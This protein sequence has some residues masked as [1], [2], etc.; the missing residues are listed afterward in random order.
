MDLWI[1]R[2]DHFPFQT[3]VSLSKESPYDGDTMMLLSADLEASSPENVFEIQVKV[4]SHIR[5]IYSKQRCNLPSDF[6]SHNAIHTWIFDFGDF[7]AKN[8]WRFPAKKPRRT[9][10]LFPALWHLRRPRP[11][12]GLRQ[13]RALP[14]RPRVRWGHHRGRGGGEQLAL[15]PAGGGKDQVRNKVR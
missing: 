10:F 13:L 3:P 6:F 15:Q 14:L 2:A 5:L 1:N 9:F 7:F 8:Y 12:P 4:V 11:V